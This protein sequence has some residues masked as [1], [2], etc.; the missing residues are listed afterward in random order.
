MN[1]ISSAFIVLVQCTL[2]VVPGCEW[3]YK[4]GKQLAGDALLLQVASE[5][6]SNNEGTRT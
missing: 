4:G 3:K 2:L 6:D 5:I 1:V